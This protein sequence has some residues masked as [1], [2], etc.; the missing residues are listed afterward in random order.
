MVLF[1]QE[2]PSTLF[3][4]LSFFVT[5]SVFTLFRSRC[6]SNSCSSRARARSWIS[7]SNSAQKGGRGSKEEKN[8]RER[9][10]EK[11]VGNQI[12]EWGVRWPE[13]DTRLGRFTGGWVVFLSNGIWCFAI[14]WEIEFGHG[15]VIMTGFNLSQLFSF[16]S[17]CIL[18]PISA[19]FSLFFV[20]YVLNS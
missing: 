18:P 1:S 11:S 20:I 9:A 19:F 13:V 12:I 10:T 3:Q 5:D 17:R 7:R 16:I 14:H 2:M 15:F 4:N 6:A 8:Q